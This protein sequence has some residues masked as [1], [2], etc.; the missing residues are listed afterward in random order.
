MLPRAKLNPEPGIPQGKTSQVLQEWHKPILAYPSL[1]LSHQELLLTPRA[2]SPACLGAMLY[3]LGF[4]ASGEGKKKTFL[5][6]DRGAGR[7]GWEQEAAV[8]QLKDLEQEQ[9]PG[10]GEFP[11][12]PHGEESKE[13]MEQE[14]RG[15]EGRV[16]RHDPRDVWDGSGIPALTR[17]AWLSS[18]IPALPPPPVVSAAGR[19]FVARGSVPCAAFSQGVPRS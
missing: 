8:L 5:G 10:K 3:S 11:H 7:S 4:V 18:S 14:A 16:A 19:G 12:H 15:V 9:T 17:A 13:K 2:A 1:F 6:W